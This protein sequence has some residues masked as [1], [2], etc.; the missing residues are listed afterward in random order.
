MNTGGPTPFDAVVVGAGPA[1]SSAAIWLARAGW[2]VALLEKQRFPRRK[3]CGEC[4]AASNLPLLQTLGV[5]AGIE[6][7]AGPNLRHV[8]ML[9][10][11]AEVS[12]DLPEADHPLHRWGR[13]LGRDTLDTLLLRQAR[14]EGADVLQPATLQ[15]IT[16][17][18]G[19]WTCEVRAV[20]SAALRVLRAALVI[21]AH[22]SWEKLPAGNSLSGSTSRTTPPRQHRA[23]DLF[24]FKANFSG[25]AL[26]DSTIS[27]LALDG[28]YGGMVMEG[29]GLATL[30]C[31]IRRDR[32]SQLRTAAPA[33]RVGDVV[34]AWLQRECAGVR[35]AVAGATRNGPWLAS[36]PLRP[37]VR[38]S[39]DD[40]ILRVGNA[41]GEA[42]PILGEG[43]SMALQSSALL[44]SQLLRDPTGRAA[45]GASAQA[46]VRER[47]VAQWR[48]HFLP[49]LRLAAAFAQLA[50]RPQPTALLMGLLR[51]HPRLLTQGARWGGKVSPVHALLPD[52]MVHPAPTP[53]VAGTRQTSSLPLVLVKPLV[54]PTP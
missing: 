8:R 41:A 6:A 35:A 47:Y 15:S 2:K 45:L 9:Q 26:S 17:A 24:A 29:A 19:A 43:I 13:A 39:T 32:L 46:L 53:P 40:P 51:T 4:I 14:A 42:H 16:G 23:S 18:A 48:R 50:M 1:G 38:I 22:G 33:Q 5:G 10:G 44:C 34:Q 21:D 49:R 3:V 52:C 20:E 36:G 30:A 11:N 12:A 28:G 31:C 37:G 27:V 25:A 54:A 7:H